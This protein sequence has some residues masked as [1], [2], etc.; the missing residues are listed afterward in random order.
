MIRRVQRS[1]PSDDAQR[2]DL[3]ITP[4]RLDRL[5]EFPIAAEARAISAGRRIPFGLSLLAVLRSPVRTG[6]PNRAERQ[7]ER[8]A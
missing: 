8:V 1:R 4:A 3:D 6:L 7:L 2:S 5:L